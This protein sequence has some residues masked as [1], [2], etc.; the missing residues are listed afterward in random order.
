MAVNLSPV[1]GV[2]AQFLD[3]NGN[4]LTG[5]KIYTYAAGTTT[6]QA[7]YTSAA[8]TTAHS[9]PIILD[10]S[11]RVPGG[12]IWLTDGLQYKV[13]IYTADNVL[14]GTYDNV[15][16]INSNFV[17]FVT[18]EEVQ[19]ATAGQT[20]FTL[21]MMQYA[22]GTNNLVVYV[23]GVNQ[24]E[25]GSY[26]YVETDSTTVTF[27]AGLHVGAV[28]K[29]VSA[30]LLSTGVVDSSS[31]VYTPAG[32]GAVTTN[33]QTK[34]RET[35]S[36][37]DFGAVGDGVVN[38]TAAIQDAVDFA[39]LNGKSLYVPSG[40]YLISSITVNSG[41]YICGD[42]PNE[43]V[44]KQ[45]GPTGS[46]MFA[47]YNSSTKSNISFNQIGFNAAFID[48][49]I[50]I[51]NVVDLTIRN[52]NFKDMPYWGICIGI[53]EPR[54]TTTTITSSDIL[55]ENCRFENTTNTFEHIVLFNAQN[56]VIRD[57]YFTLA[58]TGGIG[59]GL[60]QNLSA[61]T[62]DSCQFYEITKGIYYSITTNEIC[63]TNCRFD[64]CNVGIQG[65]NE[66]D[67]GLFGEGWVRGLLVSGCYFTNN[68]IGLEVGAVRDASLYGNHFVRNIENALVFSYGNRLVGTTI[69]QSVSVSVSDCHFL[70]NNTSGTFPALHPAILFNE[71]GN[72]MYFNFSGCTFTDV[73]TVKT[74]LYPVVFD[75]PYSWSGIR[76]F[77][78]KMTS[79]STGKSITTTLGTLSDII[80]NECTDLSDLP[81]GVSAWKSMRAVGTS[82]IGYGTGAGGTVT[83]ATS[84]STAVILNKL[85]GQITM[86]NATL[87]AGDTVGFVF[88]NSLIE[89]T[90]IVLVQVAGGVGAR[91]SYSVL[92]DT[93]GLSGLGA[94]G[95]FIT[96]ISNVALSE[97]VILNFSII[98]G[99]VS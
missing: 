56:I 68:I 8:G 28:V 45:T 4:V 50:N 48:S 63:I 97:A 43:S 99:A 7:S 87:N 5:G 86:N 9:N 71:G 21:T 74:Q 24:V 13:A 67:H 11:G 55:I 2:A 94:V 66:S 35:V 25:G 30:E 22:P 42:N 83:Q 78:C 41:L 58:K 92:A 77:G 80:L 14:I 10:A 12:E 33:V 73:Q 60:W 49:C 91:G 65:A 79:Y 38:D 18:A 54:V 34:L 98:K 64:G 6:P 51:R 31:V 89:S 81:A 47:N 15:I 62:I 70:S 76:F 16:G 72:V 52:C 29:F 90:D 75:G 53:D 23:D 57:C 3:N 27:T 59:V 46:A 1:G 32:T 84:K 82:G 40:T 39:V 93:N 19:I 61:V 96:N 37:K 17:N 26:S 44:F 69:N 88:F 20:V 95:I 36:V 85:S